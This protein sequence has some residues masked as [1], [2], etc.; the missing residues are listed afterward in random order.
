MHNFE[1]MS[2]VKESLGVLVSVL[3]IQESDTIND[4]LIKYVQLGIDKS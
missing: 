4:I 3:L 2:H 1:I